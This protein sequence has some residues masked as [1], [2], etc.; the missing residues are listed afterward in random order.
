ML[1]NSLWQYDEFELAEQ[2]R[3]LSDDDLRKVQRLAV[4]HH[5]NDPD[6][7]SGPKLNGARI[8]AR[9]MIEFVERSPR[10]TRRVRRRTTKD[11]YPP[12][13][14]EDLVRFTLE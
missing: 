6:P 13:N 5:E 14:P 9:A 10:D 12:D 3:Q 2:A 8:M 4:W 11:H 7:T 1:A